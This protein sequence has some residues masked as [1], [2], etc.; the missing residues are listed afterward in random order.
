MSQKLMNICF[1]SDNGYAPYMGLAILSILLHRGEEEVFHFYI[2]DNE[3][4]AQNKQKIESLRSTYPFEISW[5]KM[6]KDIFKGCTI[7]SSTLTVSTFGR[8]LI[9]QL[10]EADKVLY[11]D[12]DVFVRTSL[13]PLWQTDL[14]EN[15]LAGVPDYN[16][17][18]RGK[19]KARFKGEMDP[20]Q[21]VNAGVLLI[22]N[23]KWKQD[24]IF[25]Q[26]LSFSLQN[27]SMLLWLDQDAINYIC[28]KAK[29]MLP[30][31]W[32]VMGYLYKPDIFL[33]SPLYQTILKEREIA[34]IRHFHP[35][36]KNYFV[37]Q[38]DEYIELMRK[39]P[40][41]EYIPHDDPK[42]LAFIKLVL[43]YLWR[44]PFCFLLPIYYKRG[45]YRGTV[46]LFLDV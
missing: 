26:L 39:S 5:L 16:V 37:P 32:N 25:Q 19:L 11:L 12:C 17:I 46:C 14:G 30:S 40:W 13:W 27:I 7:R 31:R 10:I 44:H 29:L 15:Y 4:S 36:K 33:K 38:R 3:I 21:Y 22:N 42:P 1:A 28:R 20:Q 34:C 45:Y 18:Q 9:P 24:H 2:L 6:D 41:K 43:R 35:W 8:Y 23:K